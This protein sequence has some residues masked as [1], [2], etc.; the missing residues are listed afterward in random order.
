MSHRPGLGPRGHP[1]PWVG[2]RPRGGAAALRSGLYQVLPLAAVITL[3]S[4][5]GGGKGDWRLAAL[6]AVEEEAAAETEE[7]VPSEER[8]S[9][10]LTRSLRR[11]VQKRN[12]S[13]AQSAISSNFFYKSL[14]P[15]RMNI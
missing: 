8:T 15:K 13:V 9:C 7:K 14:M 1:H 10:T 12:G 2:R 4:R 11:R 6:A 3:I 5:G